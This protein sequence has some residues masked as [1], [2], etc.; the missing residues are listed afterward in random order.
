LKGSDSAIQLIDVQDLRALELGDGN[1]VAVVMPCIDAKLGMESAELLG[2]RAGMPCRILVAHDTVRQ[3]FIKTL[4][5]VSVRIA[6]RYVVYLAQDAY[7]GRDWLRSA[8][9]ILERSGKGLLG[10]NDGKWRGR[11]ASF[12][13]VRMNWV[14]T[15][16]GGPIFY[17]GYVSHKADNELTVIGRATNMY[18]YEPNCTL[19]EFDRDKE[20]KTSG[21]DDTKL[22][23]RRY[24]RAFDGLAPREALLEMAKEYKIKAI[25]APKSKKASSNGAR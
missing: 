5:D 3:G 19:V 16:Y 8:Y 6:A 12:G 23:E 17:H 1:A 24:V 11:I 2:R 13:M 7:P 4:N 21:V 15:L 10:F 14:R 18:L 25:W 9:D 20:F 22:F